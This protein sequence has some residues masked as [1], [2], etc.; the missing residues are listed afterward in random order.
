MEIIHMQR[1]GGGITRTLMDGIVQNELFLVLIW[2]LYRVWAV[3]FIWS[4]LHAHESS[5]IVCLWV[6]VASVKYLSLWFIFLSCSGH[7]F[8]TRFTFAFHFSV[9]IPPFRHHLSGRAPFQ[10][11]PGD[12]LICKGIAES[13]SSCL[14]TDSAYCHISSSCSAILDIRVCMDLPQTNV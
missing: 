3:R 14:V 4:S 1:I 5:V 11:S 10:L 12:I 7:D 8:L 13:R 9:S 6:A 2:G